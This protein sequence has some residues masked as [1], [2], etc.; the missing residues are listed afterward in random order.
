MRVGCKHSR[1][2]HNNSLL[3]TL[4]FPYGNPCDDPSVS[5]FQTPNLCAETLTSKGVV[6][7]AMSAPLASVAQ[8]LGET[9]YGCKDLL[10]DCVF[11]N[12][13]LVT[14]LAKLYH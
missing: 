5:V 6:L 14:C 11:F 4:E 13:G 9:I 10:Y 12:T 8:Y 7:M 3:P 2:Q 1:T